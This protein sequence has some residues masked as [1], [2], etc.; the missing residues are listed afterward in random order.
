MEPA[1]LSHSE[2][3]LRAATRASPDAHT[4]SHDDMTTMLEADPSLARVKCN[5]I[6]DREGRPMFYAMTFG[7]DG[8][9]PTPE[10]LQGA[11]EWVANMN[12]AHFKK[13]NWYDLK[14]AMKCRKAYSRE[15][16][17]RMV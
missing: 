8:K 5:T 2:E 7:H 9:T 1:Y 3:F 17:Q 14:R 4:F 12:S 16:P 10:Q 15:Y 11:K 13:L 6:V